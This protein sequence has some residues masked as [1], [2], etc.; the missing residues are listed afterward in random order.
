[1]AKSKTPK[2]DA[3]KSWLSQAKKGERYEFWRGNL[4]RA[5]N[6]PEQ[7]MS[8]QERRDHQAAVK[9]ARRAKKPLPLPPDPYAKVR[10][11]ARDLQEFVEHQEVR[12]LVEIR[13]TVLTK[14]DQRYEM[15]C[16]VQRN[17]LSAVRAREGDKWG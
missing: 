16:L 5:C 8:N 1:M 13:V 2:L 3:A 17:G 15:V 14:F 9:A 10:A 7:N 4:E 12:G 6:T 11:D